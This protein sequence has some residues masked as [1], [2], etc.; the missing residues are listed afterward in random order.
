MILHELL[1]GEGHDVY[2]ELQISNGARQYDFLRSAITASLSLGRDFLSMSVI[3]ALNFHAITCLHVNAGEFRP[4]SVRVGEGQEEYRPPEHYLV[5]ERMEEFVNVI[6]R[7]WDS[8][9]VALAAHTLW[10]LNLIHPFI[11]GNGRTAR[12]TCYYVLCLRFKQLLPGKSTLPEL[13]T[14]NRPE[15]VAALK[16]ADAGNFS[17]LHAFLAR[18]VDEQMASAAPTP[19]PPVRRFNERLLKSRMRS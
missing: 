11:N 3:K 18:L 16:A 5:Q 17:V 19:P 7:R 15:Y 14:R 8:D 4:C 6:N 10:Q 13:I 12:A 1:G 2:Q 9:P